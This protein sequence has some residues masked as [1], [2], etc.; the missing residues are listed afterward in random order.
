MTG[1]M[2][3]VMARARL[4]LSADRAEGDA[5]RLIAASRLVDSRVPRCSSQEAAA[6]LALIHDPSAQHFFARATEAR[7]LA[8]VSFPDASEPEAEAASVAASPVSAN[9]ISIRSRPDMNGQR[10]EV[11]HLAE[12][13]GRY[14][15]RLHATDGTQPTMQSSKTIMLK[16]ENLVLER[17][18]TS[19]RWDCC[20]QSS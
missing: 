3:L 8:A 2:E 6:G 4:G 20:V 14:A 13:K 16:P 10:F 11:Q 12:G 15:V 9:V 17:G 1:Q 5:E 7:R 19:D 18:T